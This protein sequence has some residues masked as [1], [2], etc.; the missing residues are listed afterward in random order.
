MK[1]PIFIFHELIIRLDQANPQIG[2]YRS[3]TSQNE[4]FILL[5]EKG[6][7]IIPEHFLEM[8]FQDPNLI[9]EVEIAILAKNFRMS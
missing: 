8:Q 1:F 9:N 2:R 4:A 3:H 5:T 6:S 7:V